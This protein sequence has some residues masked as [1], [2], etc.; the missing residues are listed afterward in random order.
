MTNTAA[1]ETASSHLVREFHR[2]FPAAINPA[3]SIY[4]PKTA[5]HYT[6]AMG[7]KGILL[8]RELWA[9]NFS[10][11]NDPTEVEYG[12]KL[13]KEVLEEEIKGGANKHLLEE[14]KT[15]LF[16]DHAETEVYVCSFTQCRDDL[17]QWRA[18][19]GTTRGTARYCIGFRLDVLANLAE[20]IS[21]S[22][23]SPV[24][25]DERAQR[26]PIKKVIT[27]AIKFVAKRDLLPRETQ[28]IAVE[29][30]RRLTRL[31]PEMKSPAFKAEEEW[32]VIRWAPPDSDEVCFDATRG[33]VRP[34][35][36][37]PLADQEQKLPVDDLLVLAPGRQAPS[38]KAANML[39][40]KSGI[41]DVEAE[42][43]KV[44]FVE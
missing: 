7:V 5:Y 28:V 3:T 22:S 14:I 9:T 44:P 8:S 18:Y 13:A 25:Y 39:L 30:A 12:R 27:Y 23:F 2:R 1:S 19:G 20:K 36:A 26:H 43:S 38:V 33:V 31:F 10:F 24:S 6:G 42:P 21:H 37:F 4:Y 11:L 34:Y 40:R 29:A 35:I 17:S 41:M 15:S 16:R 32:R